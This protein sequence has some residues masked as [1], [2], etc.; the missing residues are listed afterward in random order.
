MFSL[1]DQ[2]VRHVEQW[3]GDV[4]WI[5]QRPQERQALLKE[6][7]GPRILM[8]KRGRTCQ[9]DEKVSGPPGV[10][11]PSEEGERFFGQG[12]NVCGLA[13]MQGHSYLYSEDMDDPLLI[14]K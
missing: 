1:D 11:I 6:L 8:L 2:V 12:E 10:A 13:A 9:D 4:S 3:P 7:R 5:A 14:C